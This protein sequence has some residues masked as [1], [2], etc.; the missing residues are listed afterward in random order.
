MPHVMSVTETERDCRSRFRPSVPQIRA[1]TSMLEGCPG[2]FGVCVPIVLP[3]KT[4][5]VWCVGQQVEYPAG[6]FLARSR[7]RL[8]P[9]SYA[10]A[11]VAAVDAAYRALGDRSGVVAYAVVYPDGQWSVFEW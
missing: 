3:G 1:A 9:E 2:A 7:G 6:F 5:G 11:R 4:R 8:S 10:S